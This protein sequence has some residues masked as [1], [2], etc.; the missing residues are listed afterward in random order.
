MGSESSTKQSEFEKQIDDLASS[1]MKLSRLAPRISTP[2]EQ[3]QMHDKKAVFVIKGIDK[4]Y[5]FEINGSSE[6]HIS[7]NMNNVTTFCY[8]SSPKLFLEIVDK[9]WAGD[10]TAFQ[11]ALQR[12][13][14]VMKGPHSFHDQ[15]MWK[16]ALERLASLRKTYGVI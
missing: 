16:K 4:R 5:I 12:G 15:L 1:I 3:E 9:I 10:V 7:D 14:L 8:C 11:R 13:D 6:L 2:K